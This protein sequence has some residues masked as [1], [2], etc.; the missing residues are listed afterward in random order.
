MQT[1]VYEDHKINEPMHVILTMAKGTEQ[2]DNLNMVFIYSSSD[3]EIDLSY[4]SL[5]KSE[6]KG[7]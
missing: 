5:I 4:K 3:A 6:N 2:P 1:L 7:R